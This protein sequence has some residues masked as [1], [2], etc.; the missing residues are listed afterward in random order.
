MLHLSTRPSC[1]A[2]FTAMQGVRL[3]KGEKNSMSHQATNWAIQQRGLK[4]ATKIVLWHLCD[5]HN[6]DYGCFPSQAMLAR[7]CEM[8]ERSVRNHLEV[9]EHLG[10][11][12]RIHRSGDAGSFT[13][14]MYVFE[15]EDRFMHAKDVP[16]AK[17]ADG[18]NEQEPTAK[19]AAGRRQ[20]LPPNPVKVNPV[21]EPVKER[22]RARAL[23]S[24]HPHTD[25]SDSGEK[26]SLQDRKK[27]LIEERRQREAL[28]TEFWEAYPPCRRKTDRPK[29]AIVFDRI[30]LGKHKNIR[31]TDAAEIIEGIKRY[32]ATNPDP[33]YIPLPT[34][35]LNGAR[36]EASAAS[37]PSAKVLRYR[38]MA[39]E[40]R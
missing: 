36:W 37:S 8:S 33:K 35:W 31:K 30:I 11:I 1:S 27:H 32:A 17:S 29:A 25:F 19:F 7:D 13:S 23:F 3:E 4:P 39:N 6:P 34:T 14:N 20:N 18:K 22:A 16:T 10:L 38:N 26:P 15:F 12:R 5:R 2:R 21:I 40:G 24:D 9:L 28:F